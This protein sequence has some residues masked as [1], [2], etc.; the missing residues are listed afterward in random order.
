MRTLLAREPGDLGSDQRASSGWPASGRR[1]A[2]ADDA[3]TREV[4]L[5]HSSD[6]ACEQGRAT[7]CGVGGA[8][9][10]DQGEHGP[11]AHATDTEPRKRVPGAGPCT[12]TLQGS[13][14]RR[15]SL[16]CCTTSTVDLLREAFLAL[17]RRAAPGVDGV[18]WQ[19]YEARPGGQP[20]GS[21]CDA[22]IAAAIG[23]CPSGGG[24]S[25]SRTDKQRPLGIAALEDKI[26][27]RAVVA[28]LNAI[29]EEDFLGFSYG[30]RPGRSQ[31]DALDALS[32]AIMRYPGELDSR[33]R[34][35]RLLRLGQPGMAGPVPG[36]PDRRRARH[37]PCAQVAQGGRPGRR[38]LER[39]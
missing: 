15:S 6:E 14:R 35:P 9:G 11:T 31:H 34:H 37:P 1:G 2:E 3:R 16:R 4:R 13:G 30:F 29:Y 33:R 20:P 22:S 32:V 24:S 19:D 12:A 10:G 18:T 5:R 7:G 8:K 17:K 27:Q 28:V 26:V 36:A 38:E 25:R 39:Q 23:R 21:A